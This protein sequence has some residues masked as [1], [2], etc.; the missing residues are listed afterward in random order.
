MDVS[1]SCHRENGFACFTTRAFA[2]IRRR[3]SVPMVC[4]SAFTKG[5]TRRCLTSNALTDRVLHSLHQ[6]ASARPGTSTKGRLKRAI[7][8][9]TNVR[10]QFHRILSQKVLGQTQIAS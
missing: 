7:Q 5:A 1:L 4:V 10:Q 8:N 9:L 6:A 3:V 2:R